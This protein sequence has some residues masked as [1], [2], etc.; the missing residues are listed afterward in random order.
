MKE[1]QRNFITCTLAVLLMRSCWRLAGDLG[2]GLATPF[3]VGRMRAG[4]R[5]AWPGPGTA[6]RASFN[7]HA[8][9]SLLRF[10]SSAAPDALSVFH[11]EAYN[12]LVH[13]ENYP[14]YSFIRCP[15]KIAQLK[16]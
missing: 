4:S 16:V 2:A 11:G 6:G 9:V 12:T 8:F 15:S 5:A 13:T 14:Q 10:V 1:F 3:D 7:D